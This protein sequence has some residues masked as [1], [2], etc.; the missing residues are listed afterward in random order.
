VLEDLDDFDPQGC[1][2]ASHG[3]EVIEIHHGQGRAR[4][5]HPEVSCAPEPSPAPVSILL[6]M[7]PAQKIHALSIVEKARFCY[8]SR[9]RL[10]EPLSEM[11]GE[12]AM[13]NLLILVRNLVLGAI[14]AWLG[15]EFAPDSDKKDEKP[16]ERAEVAASVC[17]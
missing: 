3:G 6:M 1:V 16:T 17:L 8:A 14:L 15:L 5:C 12:M 10:G 4:F 2:S 9:K 11:S 13:T 7:R